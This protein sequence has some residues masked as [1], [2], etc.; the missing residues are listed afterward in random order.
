MHGPRRQRSCFLIG[1]DE[2]GVGMSF[3]VVLHDCGTARPGWA[4]LTARISFGVGEKR[5][6]ATW[7]CECRCQWRAWAMRPAGRRIV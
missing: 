3:A 5:A 6:T 4:N 7:E 1:D 2:I